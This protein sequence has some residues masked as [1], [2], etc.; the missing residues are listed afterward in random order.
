M[1]KCSSKDERVQAAAQFNRA[2]VTTNHST[3]LKDAVKYTKELN[4]ELLIADA[5][6]TMKYILITTKSLKQTSSGKSKN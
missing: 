4:L 5:S 6:V 3:I 2:L 1:Y